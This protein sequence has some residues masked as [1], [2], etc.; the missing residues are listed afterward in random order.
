MMEH[1]IYIDPYKFYGGPG[2]GMHLEAFLIYDDR[3]RMKVI[4]DFK[5]WWDKTK[6]DRWAMISVLQHIIVTSGYNFRPSR[7]EFINMN[8]KRELFPG[9]EIKTEIEG[10]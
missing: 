6:W 1:Q 3:L 5:K 8:F 9:C 7:D 4:L 2:K 10:I